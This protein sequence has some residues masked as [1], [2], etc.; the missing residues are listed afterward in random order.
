MIGSG[1]QHHH[2]A[3]SE[4]AFEHAEAFVPERTDTFILTAPKTG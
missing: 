2:S 3:F 4:D 1:R